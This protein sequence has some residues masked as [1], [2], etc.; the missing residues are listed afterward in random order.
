[1]REVCILLTAKNAVQ[2]SKYT[3]VP[4]NIVEKVQYSTGQNR[5]VQDR[6]AVKTYARTHFLF[7][8]FIAFVSSVVMTLALYPVKYTGRLLK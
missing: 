4:H 5:T 8:W 2:F 3:R 7:S 6:S 1:M